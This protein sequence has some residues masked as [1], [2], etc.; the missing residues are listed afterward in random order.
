MALY[1]YTLQPVDLNL[2]EDE[3][4]Q[5]QLQLFDA[6]N[7][8]LTKIT[9]KTWAILAVIV[10]LAIL[11][12]I[13]VHGYSTIIFWLMLVGV[14]IYLLAC[15]YGLKWYVKREF[16]KQMASQSMPPEM[17]QIKLGVQQHGVVMSM[18]APN[19]PAMPRGYNQP[20]VRSSGMQQAVIKWDSV[21]NWQETPDYIFMM[22]DVKNPKTGESQQ[23]SQIVPKRLAHQ[24]FPIDTLRHHLQ[25]NI[26]QPGFDL[27]DKPTDKYFPENN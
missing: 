11:G 22:F 1:P 14:V 12:L 26:G 10:V 15:T 13:F 20:L 3:F 21:T 4:R 19:M 25:Q 8:T 27:T 2:T 17:Q 9:P 23:G 6:N 24:K 5:A 7:Q 18:P 16:E